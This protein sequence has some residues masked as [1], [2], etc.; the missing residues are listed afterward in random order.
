MI[1][2]KNKVTMATLAASVL[3]SLHF[4]SIC[5]GLSTKHAVSSRRDV[6]GSILGGSAAAITG[7]MTFTQ[8]SNAVETTDID[9]FLRSGGVSMPMGVSGQA[10]K[11]KPETGVLLREGT[12]ISR[13]PKSGNVLAEIL[14]QKTGGGDNADNLMAVLT[15]FESPWPLATGAV[16]DVECRDGRTG[17]GAFLAVTPPL[18]SGSLADVKDQ[19]FIKSL[20]GPRG[21][22][23][24]YGQPTDIKVKKSVM[25]DDGSYK[26]LDVSFSTLSQATQTE[27]PRRSK[28]VVS[29]PK[30]SKQAVM[31]VG[32]ASA[33]RW[34]KGADKAIG[35]AVDSFR[36]TAAPQTSL[37]LRAVSKERGA[38]EL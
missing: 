14:V 18:S 2:A 25:G 7:L 6:L 33:S 29:L 30:G 10:G 28:I 5:E 34:S 13:D 37:K 32:S 1:G 31:L 11:A 8:A 21:R 20:F 19:F 3:V 17:D 38:L 24:F 36:A 15:S 26:V 9:N 16:Y 27:V 23:S 22:F 35:G 4:S 12:D